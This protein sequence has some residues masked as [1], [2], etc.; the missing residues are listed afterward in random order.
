[1]LVSPIIFVV[2]IRR[3]R[4]SGSVLFLILVYIFCPNLI[5]CF[6]LMSIISA[7][8]TIV[9]HAYSTAKFILVVFCSFD[10]EQLS[11]VRGQTAVILY[12]INQ[13]YNSV[14]QGLIE[15]VLV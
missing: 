9:Y 7:K 13:I 1:M 12:T 10:L 2:F 6:W 14:L 8:I 15:L 5:T 3:R 4:A 11:A